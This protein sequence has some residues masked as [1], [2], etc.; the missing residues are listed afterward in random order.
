VGDWR[1]VQP[2]VERRQSFTARAEAGITLIVSQLYEVCRL[3]RCAKLQRQR[4]RVFGRAV[5]CEQVVHVREDRVPQ[6]SLWVDGVQGARALGRQH[7]AGSVL[8][9]LGQ[10]RLVVCR[11]Q[12]VELVDQQGD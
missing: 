1:R 4:A 9:Q 8:R 11:R 10:K 12:R 2:Q 6:S 3:N 7:Q 5:E